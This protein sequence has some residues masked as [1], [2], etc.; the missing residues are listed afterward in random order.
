MRTEPSRQRRQLQHRRR[1]KTF[2]MRTPHAPRGRI[3]RPLG[4]AILAYCRR[5]QALQQRRLPGWEER[6]SG[7]G[8]RGIAPTE[9]AVV[10]L[11]PVPRKQQR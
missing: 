6:S 5:R 3:Q 8:G 9:C 7:G 4:I 1:S 2:R 11:S 10:L